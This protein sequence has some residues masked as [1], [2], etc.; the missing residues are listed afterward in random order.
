MCDI[1]E[2]EDEE[3]TYYAGIEGKEVN[4]RWGI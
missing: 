4:E 3:G 1:E 2:R